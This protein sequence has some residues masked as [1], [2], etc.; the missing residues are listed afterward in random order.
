MDT[1]S[2]L[3]ERKDGKR[4]LTDRFLR[5]QQHY[6]FEAAFCNPAS[7]N[8]KGHVENKVGYL[9]RNLLVPVPEFDNLIDFNKELLKKCDTDHMR[10]HY[11]KEISIETL[12]E[13]DTA[14]MLELPR[15]L[16]LRIKINK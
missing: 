10:P 15:V 4:L 8:E 2:C 5:F 3:R 14:E 9:R 7:G 13:D 16:R 12:I 11:R 6:G 1:S